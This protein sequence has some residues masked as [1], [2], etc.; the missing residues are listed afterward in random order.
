MRE[1]AGR[2][3]YTQDARCQTIISVEGTETNKE[4]IIG[5]E[6]AA[7][8]ICLCDWAP[9][10]GA[11]WT[12]LV[13]AM[14]ED[15]KR[16]HRR[17][18]PLWSPPHPP[19]T[20]LLACLACCQGSGVC[21]ALEKSPYV[22]A[23]CRDSKLAGPSN[24]QTAQCHVRETSL[25]HWSISPSSRLRFPH[26]VA[27]PTKRA[28]LRVECS[29]KE[30]CGNSNSLA[31]SG[32]EPGCWKS[33]KFGQPHNQNNETQGPYVDGANVLVAR[34]CNNAGNDVLTVCGKRPL[35]LHPTS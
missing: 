19:R 11:G 32:S 6:R 7:P 18:S 13:L 27:D 5:Q 1:A 34:H 23:S 35:L 12:S 20:R 17:P 26:A 24:Y 4:M 30:A 33:W 3:T 14:A 25:S 29:S 28:C 31:A 9:S 15:Q 2:P 8:W 21:A 16:N 10:S 22:N